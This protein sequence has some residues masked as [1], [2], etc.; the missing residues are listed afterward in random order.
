MPLTVLEYQDKIRETELAIRTALYKLVNLA[1]I[2]GV[3]VKLDV[4]M[5]NETGSYVVADTHVKIEVTF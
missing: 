2:T 1:P 4:L 3:D 5:Q